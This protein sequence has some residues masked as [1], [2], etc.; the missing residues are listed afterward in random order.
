MTARKKAEFALLYLL[1][2]LLSGCVSQASAPLQDGEVYNLF[3][4]FTKWI[5]TEGDA[6]VKQYVNPN[7]MSLY[8]RPFQD[9]WAFVI[10]K[11]EQYIG[12]FTNNST[13]SEMS[14]W[15]VGTGGY[16]QV[17]R[18]VGNIATMPVFAIP[19]LIPEDGQAIHAWDIFPVWMPDSNCGQWDN[20]AWGCGE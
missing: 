1:V 12:Y 6:L 11:G 20:G 9:G 3:P 2:L 13:W 4:G 17:A 7:G 8:A 18:F 14:K 5:A 19:I 16:T 15:L 10:A